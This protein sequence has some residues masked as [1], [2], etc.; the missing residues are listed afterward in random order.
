MSAKDTSPPSGESSKKDAPLRP[1]TG[2]VDPTATTDAIAK[3]MAAIRDHLRKTGAGFAA[4]ATLILTGLGYSQV[5]EL[6]PLPETGKW[7]VAVIGVGGGFLA[8]AS[9]AWFTGRIFGAQRRILLDEKTTPRSARRSPPWWAYFFGQPRPPDKTEDP[10]KP[11]EQAVRDRLYREHARNELAVSLE[12]VEDRA[13]RLDRIARDQ[14]GRKIADRA[15]KQAKHLIGVVAIAQ[16]ETALSILERRARDAFSGGFTK[17]LV[18]LFVVGIVMVF[19]A[20]DYAKGER[21]R[22]KLLADCQ[23]AVDE[24]ALDACDPI[25]SEADQSAELAAARKR[26][27][28]NARRTLARFEV[29]ARF[30]AA[31]PAFRRMSDAEKSTQI[32]DCAKAVAVSD[33]PGR[34]APPSGDEPARGHRGDHWFW[35]GGDAERSIERKFPSVKKVVCGPI[36]A[37]ERERY[38]ANSSVDQYGTARWD[39]FHCT[40]QAKTKIPRCEAIVHVAGPNWDEFVITRYSKRGCGRRIL[41]S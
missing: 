34:R 14:E 35:T 29:C 22:I 38:D 15:A 23:K 36:P 24:G 1:S 41:R 40:M 7:I 17:V 32:T 3:D 9:A 4:G 33:R 31:Q 2:A 37:A 28:P 39:H 5:H 20:A 10:L 11:D 16:A 19:G 18:G 6:F 26:L 21:E 13:L 8:L 30:V 12:A 27:T 25:R